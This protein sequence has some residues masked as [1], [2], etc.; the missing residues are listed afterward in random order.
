MVWDIRKQDQ[1]DKH[2]DRGCVA[3]N[4][5]FIKKGYVA[6]KDPIKEDYLID[7][8]F[9]KANESKIFVEVAVR[10]S[11]KWKLSEWNDNC[12]WRTVHILERKLK[13]GKPSWHCDK[14]FLF[15]I[16][17]DLSESF[18]IRPCKLLNYPIKEIWTEKDEWTKIID[19]PLKE[20]EIFKLST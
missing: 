6:L 19:V 2:N 13:Y 12:K 3:V 1:H 7:L 18:A 14:A 5:F 17:D 15:E 9:K 16:N 4:N 8:E 10:E 11:F 20:F